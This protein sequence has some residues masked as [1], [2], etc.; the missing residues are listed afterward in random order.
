MSAPLT[1]AVIGDSAAS[2]VGDSDGKG[3][4]FGWSYHLAKSFQEP[5]IFINAARPGARSAEV[6][7]IQLPKILIHNPDLVAVV[8]GGNDLLRS[9][10]N[11]KKFSENLRST[12][13]ELVNRGCTIMLLELHDPT[14]IVP[15]PYLIGRICRRRVSAVNAATRKLAQTF[16]AV[17]METRLQEDIYAR[18]KWHVDRMHPSKLGHQFIAAQYAKLL[19]ERGFEVGEVQIDPINNRSRKDSIKWMLKNGT[20]WFLK[21]S[22]D[23][24]PGLIWLS[25]AE[26]VFII[27]Q[28]FA[29]L[30]TQ[31][32]DL[33]GKISQCPSTI[34]PR[35]DS[36][37]SQQTPVPLAPHLQMVEPTLQSG[38]TQ[39]MPLSSASSMRSMAS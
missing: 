7:E 5:L 17:L 36:K 6:L 16:G 10:F 14:Q 25:A 18:E 30:F 15:M 37:C 23:L 32:K 8:V 35:L 1:F 39:Q 2:G 9:N 22:V 26:I 19:A 20:P 31:N 4:N 38:L 11:P 34:S 12:L 13:V 28:N 24:L 33:Q 21:R 29:R 27:R 3:N